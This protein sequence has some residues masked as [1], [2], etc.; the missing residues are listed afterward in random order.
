RSRTS[1]R[2]VSAHPRQVTPSDH[3]PI[4]RRRHTNPPASPR[5]RSPPHEPPRSRTPH[6]Q[7]HRPQHGPPVRATRAAHPHN[8][9]LH[10]LWTHRTP[11]PHP[12]PRRSPR[13]P[14]HPR[15]GRPRRRAALPQLRGGRMTLHLYPDLEQGTE[16]WMAIRRG[17]VTA[18]TIGRLITTRTLKPASNDTSRALTEQ[19]VAERI[20]GWTDPVW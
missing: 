17:I 7:I 6:P 2:P 10:E 13:H 16:E 8:R 9:P 5:P 20:T 14:R 18:S 12:R 11:R 4:R 15:M 1:S 19:L 3:L